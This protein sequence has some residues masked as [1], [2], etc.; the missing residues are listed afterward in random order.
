M[1]ELLT[2]HSVARQSAHVHT[3]V[4]NFQGGTA[5]IYVASFVCEVSSYIDE[6]IAQTVGLH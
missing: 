2:D 3:L 1:Y 4:F 6:T 5:Q